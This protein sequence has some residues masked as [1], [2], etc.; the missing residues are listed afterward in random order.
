M[1]IFKKLVPIISLSILLFS[2]LASCKLRERTVY[3]NRTTSD[4][5]S[6]SLPEATNLIRLKEDDFISIIVY[7]SDKES[8]SQFNLNIQAGSESAVGYI[9]DRQGFVNI[10]VLGKV[11]LAGLFKDEAVDLIE[12]KL[13]AYFNNPVVHISLLNFKVTV[14]GEVNSPGSYN[15]KDE[16]VTILESIGLAGDLKITGKRNNVLVIREE[17]GRKVEYRVDLTSKEIYKSPVYYLKQNDLVYVEPNKTSI[18]NSTFL[19]DNGR[20]ILAVSSVITSIFILLLK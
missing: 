7:E 20:I 2:S 3:V 4:T 17:N 11:K 13:K 16:R 6:S 19:K 8:V 12:A 9:I 10:P 1:K 18:T 5:L 14:L 15:L